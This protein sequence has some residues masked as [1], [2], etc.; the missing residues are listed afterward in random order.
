MPRL[1]LEQLES[2]RTIGEQKITSAGSLMM[3]RAQVGLDLVFSRR[4]VFALG[5]FG[6]GS[7]VGASNRIV[8]AADG[9]P[10][11][12]RPWS[13]GIVTVSG[14]GVGVRLTKRRWTFAANSRV[15]VSYM[16]MGANVV[17]GRTINEVNL[18][19]WIPS[20]RVDAE[21]CRRVGPLDHACLYIET[22]AYDTSAFNG[23]SAGLRWDFGG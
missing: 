5:G 13:T 9:S 18:S 15:A 10:L 3:W 4:W 23:G 17:T 1:T 8:T 12:M 2:D 11:E 21:L 7:A 16:W 19:G 6:V 20:L 22:R 14:P